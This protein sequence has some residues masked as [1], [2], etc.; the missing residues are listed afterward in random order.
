MQFIDIKDFNKEPKEV[1]KVFLDWWKPSICDLYVRNESPSDYQSLK[2][3]D[4]YTEFI[5]GKDSM[6]ITP[7]LTEGQLR[8]FIEDKT[9]GIV[10]VIQWHI[11]DA[12]IYKKGY[13]IDILA[14]EKYQVTHSY[15]DLGPDLLMAYWKVSCKIA[16]THCENAIDKTKEDNKEKNSVN[17]YK[18]VKNVVHNDIGVTKNEI[19]DVFRKI[20]K[21]ELINLVKDNSKFV[22]ESINEIIEKEMIKAISEHK[23]PEIKGNVWDYGRGDGK[24]LFKE[25]VSGVM[26]EEIIKRMR[27]QFD[28]QVDINKK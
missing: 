1:Q 9:G 26:R 6:E 11:E 5:I 22:Y 18:E 27:E 24:V 3:S 7:L 15:G 4:S 16:K 17:I 25:Y 10:K 20:A 13:S 28:I 14:K 2:T 8:N 12:D 21:D 19:L 23:Y